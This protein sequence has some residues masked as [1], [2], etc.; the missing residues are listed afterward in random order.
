MARRR[1]RKIIASRRMDMALLQAIAMEL[2]L[3]D[4]RII[5]LLRITS[6]L[7][8]NGYMALNVMWS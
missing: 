3:S 6:A 7:A 8:S 2:G 4:Y 5:G 1:R